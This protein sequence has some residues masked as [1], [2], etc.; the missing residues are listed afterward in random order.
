MELCRTRS[1]TSD[2]LMGATGQQPPPTNG[3]FSVPAVQTAMVK[4]TRRDVIRYG[5]ALVCVVVAL[6]LQGIVSAFF[7][8]SDVPFLLSLTAVIVSALY[9]GRGPGILATVMAAV[10]C[11]YFFLHTPFAFFSSSPLENL[12]IFAKVLLFAAEGVL[13]SYLAEMLRQSASQHAAVTSAAADAIVTIDQWGQVVEFNPAAEKMFGHRRADVLGKPMVELIVPFHLR[14]RHR[15]GL[16]RCLATGQSTILGKRVEMPALR[17]NGTEFPVELSIMRIPVDGPPIFTSFIRDLSM[18]KHQETRL[19]QQRQGAAL[20]RQAVTLSSATL[21]FE[22]A[23]QTSLD[24]VCEITSWPVGHVYLPD[25][26]KG[27]LVSSGI[28][29]CDD[30]DAYLALKQVTAS[31]SMAQGEGLP[32]RIWRSGAPAWIVNVERDDNFP[33]ARLG[34][35]LGVKGAFGFPV[36]IGD[37]VVAVM[38]FFSPLEMTPDAQ[39]LQLTGSIGEQ[40]G[41]VIQRQRTQEEQ[42]HLAAIVDSTD[43]A[44]IG[45]SLDGAITSWNGAAERLF[46]YTASEAIGLDVRL[47]LPREMAD[48]EPALCEAIR[49]GGSLEQ[50]EATRRRRDGTPRTVSL[51]ISPIR[52]AA[53]QII[54]SSMAA[55]DITDRKQAELMLRREKEAAEAANRTKSEFLANV[56]HEVRTPMNAVLGMLQLALREDLTPAI[57]DYLKTA[58]DSAENLMFLLNDL[59]DLSRAEAGKFELETVPFSLRQTLEASIKPL[60]VRAREKELQ[61]VLRIDADV[62]DWLNGDGRRLRQVVMNLVGNAIKFTERGEIVVQASADELAGDKTTVHVTVSDTGVGI[63][64]EDQA[65]VFQPFTQVNASL[66]RSQP[67]AGLGLAICSELVGHMG[68]RI[69]VESELGRGSRFHFTARF[70][71]VTA[72]EVDEIES[73]GASQFDV[74]RSGN[75]DGEDGLVSDTGGTLVHQARALNVLLAEDTRA[76]QKLVTAILAKRGHAVTVANHGGEAIELVQQQPFDVVLM[77]V[78]MPG[79]DG[80]EA[81]AAI[82]ALRRSVAQIPIIAMT[83]HAMRGDRE[84]CLA[85]G[86]NAYISKPLDASELV[87]VV[88]DLAWSPLQAA[89]TET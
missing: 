32:G 23:M 67:G 79:M 80:F 22:E 44:V 78:Q 70:P 11:D 76:N 34:K 73:G 65:R 42:S 56:S 33:L 69:W 3:L 27:Q 13:I 58:A 86:M 87:K 26:G 8:I 7:G 5:L 50:F 85:A 36:K 77:D 72:S 71:V 54:G 15:E 55:R 52:D 28:W 61:L 74:L 53:G 20:L 60:S 66:S 49:S 43:D 35:N 29:H 47:L 19:A 12:T 88:E 24:V 46:G 2:C 39:L 83:A 18:Q 64:P 84:R 57:R 63:A 14:Q 25:R 31:K 37:E 6:A 21:S 9:G 4:P 17:S 30:P 59:L 40:L 81:T 75:R 38:E 62:P 48:E 51:T 10:L 45:R 82:R 68:G 16:R 1:I 41:R 89:G